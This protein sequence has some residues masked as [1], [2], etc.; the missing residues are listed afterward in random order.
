MTWLGVDGGGTKT[1]ALLV[2]D[3]RVMGYARGGPANHQG[4]GLEA[5]VLEIWRTISQALEVAGVA[6]DAVDAAVLGLAGADFPEDVAALSEGLASYFARSRFRVVNDAEIALAAGTSKGYGI[7]AVA[8]TGGNVFGVNPTGMSRQV[9]GLGYEYGDYGSG[10]DIVRDVLHAAFR[11][12][13]KRGEKTLLEQMV[14]RMLGL[15]DYSALSRALYF[16]EIPD[17][18]LIVMAPLC[19][20]AAAQGDAVSIGILERQGQ[21]IAESVVGCARLL[22]MASMPLD[23][24]MAGSLWLG[25]APHMKDRFIETLKSGLPYADP[26]LTELRPVAGA[27]LLAAGFGEPTEDLRQ[28]LLLDARFSG[29]E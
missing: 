27:A 18:A 11:S 1:E 14:L 9:G 16:K 25:T 10:I 12:A 13:E 20:Q 6:I 7:A 29:V 15:P 28:Q 8:G 22:D 26:Q 4:I 24:V 3:Q 21:A 5:A 2:S 17:V 23:V 19:F